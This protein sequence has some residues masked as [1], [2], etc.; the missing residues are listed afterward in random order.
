M[1][2]LHTYRHKRNNTVH[3]L[4]AKERTDSG[5]DTWRKGPTFIDSLDDFCVGSKLYPKTV[6]QSLAPG[7]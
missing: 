4:H 6:E 1:C 7:H 2:E 3:N 5:F